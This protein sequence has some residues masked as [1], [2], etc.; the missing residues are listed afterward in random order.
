[1]TTT[2]DGRGDENNYQDFSSLLP[3]RESCAVGRALCVVLWMGRM[4]V[5]VRG[6]SSSVNEC[7]ATVISTSVLQHN[8][9]WNRVMFDLLTKLSMGVLECCNAP[10]LV[11][12]VWDNDA[13][14]VLYWCF[15][16]PVMM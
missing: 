16:I 8:W 10:R 4:S 14:C 15:K 11:A 9:G 6:G 12:F 3:E 13:C 1:M 2:T 5:V 7:L